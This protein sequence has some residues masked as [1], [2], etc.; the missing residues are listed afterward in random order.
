MD[1]SSNQ[2]ITFDD[3][4]KQIDASGRELSECLFSQYGMTFAGVSTA[5][6]YAVYRKPPNGLAIMIGA[7]VAG[8]VADLGYAWTSACQVQVKQ[9]SDLRKLQEQQIQEHTRRSK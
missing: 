4:S 6:A 1:S 8:T 3:L 2:D 7:G 5:T 9:W